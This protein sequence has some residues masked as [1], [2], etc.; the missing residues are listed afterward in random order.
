MSV[1]YVMITGT[2]TLAGLQRLLATK[3]RTDLTI[4]VSC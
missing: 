4:K 2:W 3:L 1:G